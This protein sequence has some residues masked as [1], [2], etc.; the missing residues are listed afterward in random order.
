MSDHLN[1]IFKELIKETGK[2]EDLFQKECKLWVKRGLQCELVILGEAPLTTKQFF[3]NKKTG[4]YLS[5]LKQHYTKAKELKDDDFKE[6][7]RAKGI[8]NL[9]IYQYPLPTN[10]YDND[11]D[12]ILF[13][14]I[15]VRNR[16]SSLTEMGIINT[17]TKY[18]YRYQKLL[19]R[20]LHLKEPFISLRKENHITKEA[21]AIG[22]NAGNIN[23]N[24][25]DYLPKIDKT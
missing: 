5:F 20:K 17:N 8:L 14:E 23:P 24:L 2:V 10:F 12:S 1:Y 3:Y 9:D 22:A 15:F 6:F 7:L 18:V 25:I 11:K 13:D 4:K 16:I 21:I 19:D